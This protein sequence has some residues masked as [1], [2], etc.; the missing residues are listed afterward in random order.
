MVLTELISNISVLSII[1][2]V[3]G[4]IFIVIEMEMPGFGV[5]GVLGV[6]SLVACIFVTAK[7]FTQGIIMTSVLIVVVV[8]LL[9]VMAALASKGYLPKGMKL[10]E[11]TSA[12]LGFSGAKDMKHL[13]G[14]TGKTLT[15]LRPV[16]DADFDGVRLDVISRGEYIEKDS[17]IEVIE[18]EGNRIVVR[19]RDESSVQK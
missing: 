6:I 11:S 16:G 5:F 10:T 17:V 9:A 1:L 15:K 14:K 18:V 4:I 7:T 12:E 3:V 2:F 19:A 13:V 8:I